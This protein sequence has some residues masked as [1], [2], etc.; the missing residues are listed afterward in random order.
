MIYRSWM[1]V[2]SLIFFSA[3]AS[4][5]SSGTRGGGT[6]GVGD[7][8][9]ARGTTSTSRPTN[10]GGMGTGSGGG[11]AST[12]ASIAMDGGAPAVRIVGRY[13]SAAQGPKFDWSGTSIHARFTGT[14]VSINLEGSG[15]E[16]AVL[17]D[18]T[19][20]GKV[21]LNGSHTYLLATGLSNATHEIVVWRR[22][23][24]SFGVDQFRGFT[25]D[26]GGALQSPPAP[27][28]RRIEVVG[29]SFTCGYGN[30]GTLGCT[31]SASTE[32]NYLAYAAVA[33]RTVNAELS[34]VAWSG[35]GMWRNYGATTASPD[36]MPTLYDFAVTGSKTAWDFSK[37]IPDVVAIYLGIN[38]S[39]THGDP[40]QPY[41][42]AYV[43]FVKHVRAKY[44]DAWV[45][46]VDPGLASDIQAVVT[47]VKAGGDNKIDTVNIDSTAGGLG[48][49]YHPNTVKDAEMGQKLATKLKSLLAW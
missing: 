44:P 35:R 33:A 34:T 12:S 3:V 47:A 11:T 26:G 2:A 18:G 7:S 38:D 1:A 24:A 15:S 9:G 37:F 40:G 16:Y 25:F 48:C 39:S 20:K 13:D 31:F 22:S 10:T 21:V 45:L 32:N 49:D 8:A 27:L 41:V 14:A 23:E 30:E 46:C 29:D 36:A 19:D 43:A 5:N 42:D 28:G 4:C 17:V 6:S